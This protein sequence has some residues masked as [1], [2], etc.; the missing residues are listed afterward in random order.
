[1]KRLR[2]Q[3]LEH[4][5]FSQKDLSDKVQMM[6]I[7]PEARNYVHSIFRKSKQKYCSHE[8]VEIYFLEIGNYS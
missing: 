5:I 4:A 7:V 2:T 6:V 1:M 8:R 3:V